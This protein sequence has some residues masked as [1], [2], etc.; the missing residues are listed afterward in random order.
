ML[1]PFLKTSLE[2]ALAGLL[3]RHVHLE[4]CP[5]DHPS[6]HPCEGPEP[7]ARPEAGSQA[8]SPG[9]LSAW[10]WPSL[11]PQATHS[12]KGTKYLRLFSTRSGTLM[13]AVIVSTAFSGIGVLQGDLGSPRALALI[14]AFHSNTRALAPELSMAQ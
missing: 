13:A 9:G 2:Q 4:Q 14:P 7:T 11:A 12:L 1:P 3:T 8:P 5:L 6:L 10:V